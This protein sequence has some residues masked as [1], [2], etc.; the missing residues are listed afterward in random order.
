MKY[1]V[2]VAK[3]GSL[4]KAS[5]ILLIAQP[6]LSRSIKDLESDLG[7]VIFERT[8]RGMFL[9]PE[10]EEFINYAKGILDQIEQVE[11]YYRENSGRKQ[12]FSISVPRACYISEAFAEFSKSLTREPAEVFYKETN[13]QSTIRNILEN[14]YNL[15]II[16]YAEHYDRYFKDMLEEKDICYELVTEFR[17]HLLMSNENPLAGKQSISFEDLSGLIEI[18][19]ADPY[20]PSMPLSKVMK[21]ELPDNIDR[22]IFIYERGSQFDLLSR[23]P[24]TFMWVSLVPR[25]IIDRYHL[26]ERIC[27]DN[28]KV[29]KDVLVY[30]NGYKLSQLDKQFITA[31]CEAKRKNKS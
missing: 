7:I 3:C 28:T 11:K 1:A 4:N 14:N 18:A 17:Y 10:G 27:I 26:T 9:T 2:E 22:R 31:L 5:E 13:S 16:R 20:V 21:E 8:T 12:K 29:Y 30:R 24:E 25:D 6:N 19:H 15:G 23:N